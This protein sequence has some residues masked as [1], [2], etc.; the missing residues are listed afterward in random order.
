MGKDPEEILRRELKLKEI[1]KLTRVSPTVFVCKCGNQVKQPAYQLVNTGVR[2]CGRSGCEYRNKKTYKK[3]EKANLSGFTKEQKR[4]W[5]ARRIYLK[6]HNLKPE[7]PIEF[8]QN[9]GSDK[10][11]NGND[12][13]YNLQKGRYEDYD[14]KI[15]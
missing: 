14:L 10:D 5:V 12:R 8:L 2:N 13:V 4:L 1:G 3:S 6:R 7:T 9:M 15:K 11:A